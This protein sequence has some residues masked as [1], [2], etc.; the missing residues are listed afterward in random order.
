M[1]IDATSKGELDG[2]NRDWPDEIMMTDEIKK[3]VDK[4]WTNYR[5]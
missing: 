5:I 2:F 4:K 3:L 1:G